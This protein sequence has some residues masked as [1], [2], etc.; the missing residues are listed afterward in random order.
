MHWQIRKLSEFRESRVL[1]CGYQYSCFNYGFYVNSVLN[2][3][4]YLK[5]LSK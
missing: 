4:I 3:I 2:V 5:G 1:Q